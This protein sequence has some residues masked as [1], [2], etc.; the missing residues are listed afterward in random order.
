[1]PTNRIIDIKRVEGSV[2]EPVTL[3]QVKAHLIITSADD[4]TLLTSLITQARKSIEE[5]CAISIVAKTVTLTADLYKEWE[6]PYGPVTGVT[7]VATTS[8]NSEGSGPQTFT[9]APTGWSTDGQEFISFNPGAIGEW[10]WGDPE[11]RN[12]NSRY[13]PNRYKIIYTVGYGTVPE[14]LKLAILNEI[15][16]RFERRG[17]GDGNGI[18]EAARIIANPFKRSLWF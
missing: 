16:Y 15:A 7:Y 1:M 5:Y 2:T 9:T 3:T 12:W 13:W 10:D 17:E 18:C 6:L 4:D 11:P 8:P 14:D